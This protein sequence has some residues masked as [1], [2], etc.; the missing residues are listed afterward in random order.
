M[1]FP[2]VGEFLNP[3]Q[4]TFGT[5]APHGWN[6]LRYPDPPKLSGQ[7]GRKFAVDQRKKKGDSK[8]DSKKTHPMHSK[9]RHPIFKKHLKIRMQTHNFLHSIV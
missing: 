9:Q 1:V 5:V 4:V 8:T 2:T 7:V 6:M 3:N